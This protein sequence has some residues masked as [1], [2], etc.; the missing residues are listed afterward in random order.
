MNGTRAGQRSLDN[1]DKEVFVECCRVLQVEETFDVGLTVATGRQQARSGDQLL[2]EDVD[3]FDVAPVL[4]HNAHND[5]CFPDA[6]STFTFIQLFTFIFITTVSGLLGS[7]HVST[8]MGVLQIF[9]R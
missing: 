8:V 5:R 9:H 1:N 3:Q 4:P 7:A 6:F 2:L